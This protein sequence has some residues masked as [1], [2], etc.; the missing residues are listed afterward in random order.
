[1]IKIMGWQITYIGLLDKNEKKSHLY[2]DIC[3]C[4]CRKDLEQG[5]WEEKRL[6]FVEQT[7]YVKASKEGL[8]V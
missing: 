2:K 1:M 5:N 8:H 7:V 6:Q 4:I 3:M